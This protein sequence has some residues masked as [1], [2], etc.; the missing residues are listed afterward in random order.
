MLQAVDAVVGYTT[1]I[2]LVKPLLAGKE[3]V[4]T[5][6]RQ[7]VARVEAAIDLALG[8]K[9]CAIVSSGGRGGRR[10]PAG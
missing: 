6:M 10:G 4:A 9:S 2:D 1:Y 3:V 8:G 5:G 7:E